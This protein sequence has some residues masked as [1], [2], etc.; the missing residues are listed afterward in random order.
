[1]GQSQKTSLGFIEEFKLNSMNYDEIIKS[2]KDILKEVHGNYTVSKFEEI[3]NNYKKFH[4]NQKFPHRN[5]KEIYKKK[6]TR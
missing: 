2:I 4:N 3:L 1:M 5:L 6:K